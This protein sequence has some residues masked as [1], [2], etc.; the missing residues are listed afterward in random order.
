M[1]QAYLDGIEAQTTSLFDEWAAHA[2]LAASSMAG[3]LDEMLVPSAYQ[4][5]SC[6]QTA[7]NPTAIVLTPLP[8]SHFQICGQT[9]VCRAR[10]AAA[11]S[12]FQFELDRVASP[13]APPSS[14]DV[15][16]ESPLFNVY[17]PA[18]ASTALPIWAV[19]SLPAANATQ[20]CSTRCGPLADCMAVVRQSNML[21]VLDF[22]CM[23]HPS[24]IQSTL[25][26]TTLDSTQLEGSDTMQT[27]EGYTLMHVDLLWAEGGAMPHVV[28]YTSLTTSSVSMDGSTTVNTAH[29]I[30]VWSDDGGV[31]RRI[32]GTDD[33]A[34]EMLTVSVQRALFAG[35][36]LVKP[37][38]GT[39]SIGMVYPILPFTEATGQLVFI[40]AFTAQ[41]KGWQTVDDKLST[42]LSGF[43]LQAIVSWDIATHLTASRY[44]V[45]CPLACDTRRDATCGGQC[46]YALD[47]AVALGYTGTFLAWNQTAA[48]HLPSALPPYNNN[49]ALTARKVRWDPSKGLSWTDDRMS[50]RFAASDTDTLSAL[51]TWTRASVFS[52]MSSVQR[53]PL[54][55]PRMR[56]T[57]KWFQCNSG[58]TS[59]GAWVFESRCILGAAGWQIR[60]FRSQVVTATATLSQNCTYMSCT[61]CATARLRLMCHQAQDCVLGQCV[62]TVV[63]T[64]DVLCG[65]GSVL[66]Q[67]ALHAITTWRALF[68][69]M[70]E[71]GLLAMRG[72]SG[73][74]IHHV[75]LRFPTDQVW[76]LVC[77]CKDTYAVMTGLGVSIGN[78][79]AAAAFRTSGTSFDLTG[80]QDIGALAGE[81][82][83][84]S[85]AV[86]GLV[87]NAVSS[88]T[89]LPTLALHRWLLCMANSSMAAASIDGG[90]SF[91]IQFGDVGMDA[92]WMACANIE[93]LQG[94]LNSGDLSTASGSA[95]AI[96]VQF[97]TSLLSGLGE[98]VLY[99]M[100]LSFTATV[101]YATSLVWGFQDILYTFNM[102]ACKL[103][104]Y[105][106][107][108]VLQCACNDDAYRIPSPQRGHDWS[109]GALWCVGT[110]SM[111]LT[112]GTP[113]FVYNPYSLDALSDGVQGVTAYMDCLSVR[114]SSDCPPPL[115][116]NTALA[117]LVSQGVE[118]LAVWAR[119]K[120]NYAMSTWDVGA[121]AL[122]GAGGATVNMPVD[123]QQR[124][125]AWAQAAVGSAF[126]ECLKDPARLRVDYAACMRL[127]FA[128]QSPPTTP[129]A[130]YL[131]M[132]TNNTAEPPDACR[133][134][135]GLERAAPDA[136]PL[137]TLMT[138]CKME[139]GVGNVAACDL[140]PLVWGGAQQKVAVA[141][142]HGTVPPR[143]ASMEAQA[144]AM[145]APVIATLQNAY[146]TWREGY[147][148]ESGHIDAF[149]FS[150]DGDLMHQFFDCV[151]MGPY[152]RVDLRAC[153]AEVRVCH[154]SIRY[155]IN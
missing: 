18:D 91:T 112:D 50:Y 5:G 150:A 95:V 69:G 43:N 29:E 126:L 128:A 99:G 73:E 146:D 38:V 138:D 109:H 148:K 11:I 87:F 42:T 147:G 90:S 40:V 10:C 80:S 142:V 78:A 68:S 21:L 125:V 72:L 134:F 103:P 19:A 119:C 152:S 30:W 15:A 116:E 132:P 101:D 3:V 97:A 9:S 8:L 88:A 49:D 71:L 39:C 51:G 66:E 137:Q 79:L 70:M 122:F 120:S 153:D 117:V 60:A 86:A 118:P 151:F 107:R 63:Q 22:F 149:V 82:V 130:Y 83:L 35:S 53:K 65:I 98:T 54:R 28:V 61:G 94:L 105:A 140:N 32:I 52:L 89:L 85:T 33:L 46:Q 110:L 131:Y 139:Q 104:N 113:A 154:I 108:Y 129:A 12:L 74:M 144:E 27:T 57:L 84:K 6:V 13:V 121:G 62:G 59:V 81:G 25:F 34:V 31:R 23:P 26:P 93:G 1:C 2:E 17:A 96:F 16:A 102:R 145:Y 100:Q 155:L 56:N 24:E 48:F 20:G 67:S 64:R 106:M 76:A 75:T 77:A 114:S 115:N 41:I 123:V 135:T 143:A 7:N 4:G 127:F 36:T 37:Q 141:A 47:Q 44:F 58:A 124:A 136:S 55:D 111:V 45:P 14:F 92:S 133:V